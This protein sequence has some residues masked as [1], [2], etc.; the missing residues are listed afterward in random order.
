MTPA[1]ALISPLNGKNGQRREG[2][3]YVDVTEGWFVADKGG[4]G[5]WY[6]ICIRDIAN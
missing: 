4:G 2:R 6:T 3:N 1:G 5:R